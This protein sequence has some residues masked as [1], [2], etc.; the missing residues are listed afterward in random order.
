MDSVFVDDFGN[1][2]EALTKVLIDS[3]GLSQLV[4]LCKEFLQGLLNILHVE[5]DGF[6]VAFVA[7]FFYQLL[8]LGVSFCV[9]I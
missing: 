4:S 1:I 9:V 8:L 3:I 5:F 2:F 6:D 7:L